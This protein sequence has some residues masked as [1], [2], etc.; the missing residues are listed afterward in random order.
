MKTFFLILLILL[1]A[2]AAL[3]VFAMSYVA[4]HATRQTD[5]VY[6]RAVADRQAPLMDTD[7]LA[8][9]VTDYCPETPSLSRLV[10]CQAS[11][12]LV[13]VFIRDHREAFLAKAR[14][15]EEQLD[16]L[17]AMMQAEV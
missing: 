5:E 7:E 17:N 15:Y 8:N 1:F 3:V 4:G 9:R 14:L 16:N 10:I 12:R 11:G 13:T 2:T 6:R